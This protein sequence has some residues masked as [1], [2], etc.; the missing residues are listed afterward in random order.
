MLRALSGWVIQPRMG[1]N[2]LRQPCPQGGVKWTSHTTRSLLHFPL[3]FISSDGF[4][5]KVSA[6]DREVFFFLT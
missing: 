2:L 5:D 6:W 4:H 3:V 1:L